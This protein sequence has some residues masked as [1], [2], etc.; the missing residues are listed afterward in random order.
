MDEQSRTD[1][2]KSLQLLSTLSD[3]YGFDTAMQALEEAVKRG[4]LNLCDTA[5]L[6]AR[7]AGYGLDTPPELGP[8]L[9]QYDR[10]LQVEGGEIQ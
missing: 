10:L 3:R 6:A 8:D 9:A 7:L 4:S 1:L 2:R 5:V